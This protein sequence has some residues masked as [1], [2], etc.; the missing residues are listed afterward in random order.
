MRG[1]GDINSRCGKDVSASSRRF[2]V[3]RSDDRSFYSSRSSRL[4]RRNRK[5]I[6]QFGKLKCSRILNEQNA[7]QSTRGHYR[8]DCCIYS[9]DQRIADKKNEQ[10]RGMRGRDTSV[11]RLSIP[12]RIETGCNSG[13]SAFRCVEMMLRS[14]LAGVIS[15]LSPSR[16]A[17]RRTFAV[18]RDRKRSG[19][20]R[21]RNASVSATATRFHVE[22]GA[23]LVPFGKVAVYTHPYIQ[24]QKQAGTPCAYAHVYR[25]DTYTYT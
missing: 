8:N 3:L 17:H 16:I 13:E 20:L 23:G 14:K 11:F 18:L 6:V 2:R 9:S 1:F 19:L 24:N 21:R 5:C 10:A 15:V 25:H 4:A 12:T 22:K 7:C